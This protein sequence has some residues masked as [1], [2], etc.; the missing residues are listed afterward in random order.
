MVELVDH[1]RRA[2]VRGVGQ[3]SWG[4]TIFA[5]CESA[6]K[7]GSLVREFAEHPIAKFCEMQIAAPLN[8]G[9]AVEVIHG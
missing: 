4:P 8:T 9:A 2:G 1:L 5:L 6:G 7:A 3:T